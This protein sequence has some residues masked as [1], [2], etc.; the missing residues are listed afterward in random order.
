M[1]VAVQVYNP[2]FVMVLILFPGNL[3][4]S[5]LVFRSFSVSC[6]ADTPS[7]D[8]FNRGFC[9]ERSVNAAHGSEK[10]ITPSRTADSGFTL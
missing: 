10:M 2:H 9:A 8:S 7:A 4:S 6:R 1:E 5:C 3:F